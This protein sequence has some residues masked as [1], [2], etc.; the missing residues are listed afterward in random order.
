MTKKIEELKKDGAN[1]IHNIME[2]MSVNQARWFSVIL[3]LVVLLL[4]VCTTGGR[5]IIVFLGYLGFILFV[6]YCGYVVYKYTTSHAKRIPKPRE[7]KPAENPYA[8]EPEVPADSVDIN[9]I[10]ET[11]EDESVGEVVHQITMDE[12]VENQE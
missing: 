5:D 9:T 1:I 4:F 7:R 11:E 3:T 12:L 8:D 10:L 6:L 2:R